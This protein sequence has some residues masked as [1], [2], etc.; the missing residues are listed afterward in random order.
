MRLIPILKKFLTRSSKVQHFNGLEEPSAANR[1]IKNSQVVVSPEEFEASYF[2]RSVARRASEDDKDIRPVEPIS[3]GRLSAFRIGMLDSQVTLREMKTESKT[4]YPEGYEKFGA[5]L[6]LKKILL[7]E[8][9]SKEELFTEERP[10]KVQI[11]EWAQEVVML[12]NVGVLIHPG[13]MNKFQRLVTKQSG[14]ELE[15]DEIDWSLYYEYSGPYLPALI[16]RECIEAMKRCTN[17]LPKII[18]Y[19][20]EHAPEVAR[21]LVKNCV[22]SVSDRFYYQSKIKVTKLK[23]AMGRRKA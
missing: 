17:L 6:F 19:A 9:L 5:N 11:H 21:L 18:N 10:T 13:Q 12:I 14:Q 15:K 23:S 7:K 4:L 22:E 20:C 2:I 8:A 16:D 3:R 1:G